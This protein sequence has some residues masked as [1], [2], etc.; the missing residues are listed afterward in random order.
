VD[1]GTARSLFVALLVLL[2]TAAL[3][4]I[5]SRAGFSG[6][7]GLLGLL[8]GT[9]LLIAAALLAFRE[10]PMTRPSEPRGIQP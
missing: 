9:G 5:F 2:S 3:W 6:A 7:W 10:W 1:A 4:R 8:P